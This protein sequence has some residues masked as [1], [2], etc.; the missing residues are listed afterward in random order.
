MTKIKRLTQKEAEAKA[1]EIANQLSGL[2]YWMAHTI[3]DN[4]QRI[5]NT[6]TIVPE[7]CAVLEDG[8]DYVPEKRTE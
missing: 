5:I 7:K 3:L 2:P 4:A 8:F 1:M 6:C